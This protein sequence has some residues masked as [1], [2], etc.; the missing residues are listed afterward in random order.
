MRVSFLSNDQ[1]DNYGRYA[2]PPSPHD[3]ARN[4]LLDDTRIEKGDGGNDVPRLQRKKRCVLFADREVGRCGPAL[5]AQDLG[6]SGKPERKDRIFFSLLI[7]RSWPLTC[8]G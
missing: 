8:A 5:S 6:G 4:F 7:F 3:L 2:G 1:R